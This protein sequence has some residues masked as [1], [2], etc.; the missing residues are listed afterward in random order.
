LRTGDYSQ[1][2]VA[3]RQLVFARSLSEEQ[4][5]VAVNAD[6]HP[7]SLDLTAPQIADGRLVDMLDPSVC[8][9]ASGGRLRLPGIPAY[10]ARILRRAPMA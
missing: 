1:V 7:M 8:V 9:D 6:S 10:G 3:D 4:V 2:H 5:I